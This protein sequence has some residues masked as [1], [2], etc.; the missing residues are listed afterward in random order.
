MNNPFHNEVQKLLKKPTP[1]PVESP[2][3][4]DVKWW[5]L[6]HLY[7]RPAGKILWWLYLAGAVSYMQYT[8]SRDSE[9]MSYGLYM[10]HVILWMKQ[11]L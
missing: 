4:T 10:R 6:L 9:F 11:V 1:P 7:A 5:H 8:Q 2:Q 3:D